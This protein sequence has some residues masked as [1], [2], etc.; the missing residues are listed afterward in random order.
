MPAGILRGIEFAK[1][2]TMLNVGDE[3]IMMSDG[4]TDIN[5]TLLDEFI[6]SNKTASTN[7]KAKEILDFAIE[8]SDARHRDDMSIIVARLIV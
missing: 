6:K 7:E 5:E 4:I 3:I 2:T 1:R 8:N